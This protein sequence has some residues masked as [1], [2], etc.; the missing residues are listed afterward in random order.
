MAGAERRRW[1][2]GELVLEEGAEG[3]ALYQLV[4]GSLKVAL[5]SGAR[6]A[7]VGRLAAGATFGERSLLAGG[8]AGAS[9]I[10]EGDVVVVKLPAATSPPSVPPTPR[11][12]RRCTGYSRRCSPAASAR[13]LSMMRRTCPRSR[14]RPAPPRRR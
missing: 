12:R 3:R 1:R 4:K 7:I 14:C 10:A 11:C 13:S 5:H 6:S 9:L 8:G 2:D